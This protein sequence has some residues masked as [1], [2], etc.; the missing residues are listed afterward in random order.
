[1]YLF[2][3]GTGDSFVVRDCETYPDDPACLEEGVDFARFFSERFNL[4]FVSMRVENQYSWEPERLSPAFIMLEQA[5]TL[6]R[7]IRRCE[8]GAIPCTDAE[9][10][11]W[12]T[13]L[14]SLESFFLNL[15]D[16]QGEYGISSWL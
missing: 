10:E 1:M 15:M 13:Q 12:Y 14:E 3:E 16:I 9:L 11:T 8:R 6:Q 5:N 2:V 7:D 4:S